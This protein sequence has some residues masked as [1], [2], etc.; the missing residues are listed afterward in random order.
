[1]SRF[2]I[3]QLFATFIYNFALGAGMSQFG[4][5]AAKFNE[6]K[7]SPTKA[8]SEL[9]GVAAAQ[10]ASFFMSFIMI[11]VRSCKARKVWH[12]PCVLFTALIMDVGFSAQ[13]GR[14]YLH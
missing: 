13:M 14:E 2:F 11:K 3:F 8:I 9:L 4:Q 1:M 7:D 10:Q 6:I 5:M 12:K